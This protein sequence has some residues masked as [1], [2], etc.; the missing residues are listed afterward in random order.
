MRQ[1]RMRACLLVAAT[2]SVLFLPV[3]TVSADGPS[4]SLPAGAVDITTTSWGR[5]LTSAAAIRYSAY[6]ATSAN[7]RVI[8]DAAGVTVAP[9][10]TEFGA[11]LETL[12]DGTTAL[13]LA[14]ATLSDPGPAVS[15]SSESD[16][17]APL[18]SASWSLVGNACFT[19]ISDTW[20]W[21]DHC[22]QMYK[23]ANDGSSTRDY[24]ALQHYAT[25]HPNSP[26]VGNWAKIRSYPTGGSAAQNWMDW[27][28]R[29]DYSGGSRT[30]T[31]LG[32]SVYVVLTMQTT[33][34]DQWWIAKSNPAVDFSVEWYRPGTRNN[35]ELACEIAVWV[36]QG[37][38]PQWYLPAETHG[39]SI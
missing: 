24:Y 30:T 9:A 12:A 19:R 23:L 11:V 16:G 8:Q 32:I 15:D 17:P 20:T 18:V 10:G 36:N 2:V 4:T 14:P 37:A 13:S 35:R 38:W 22:Y 3:S 31:T 27:S 21:L 5:Q 1:S 33:M 6:G 25:M 26:W 39:S 7:L 29:G 28:P 34:C